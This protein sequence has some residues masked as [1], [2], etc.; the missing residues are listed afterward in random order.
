VA[1]AA[2]RYL[3]AL[4]GE[5]WA[6]LGSAVFTVLGFRSVSSHV[7]SWGWFLVAVL[8]FLYA[9]ARLY[10]KLDKR[11]SAAMRDPRD[12]AEIRT[13]LRD[14]HAAGANIVDGLKEDLGAV[15]GKG[16]TEMHVGTRG[17]HVVDWR[18]GTR[19]ELKRL[20][21]GRVVE[22]DRLDSTPTG[23]YID[24][25][26]VVRGVDEY[27]ALRSRL[28][29]ELEWLE[30]MRFAAGVAGMWATGTPKLADP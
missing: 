4:T 21:P 25:N 2:K 27:N 8:L 10:H 14:R 11:L 22:F 16:R 24:R 17:T 13:M 7:P 5:A 28:E 19:T 15:Y 29:A 6:V 18:A 9:N 23:D 20:L 3:L 26:R 30:E 1:D 12:L